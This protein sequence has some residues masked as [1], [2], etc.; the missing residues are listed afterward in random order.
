MTRTYRILG[1]IL[2]LVFGAALSFGAVAAQDPVTINWWHISTATDQAA[3]WQNL[4][5]E[6]TAAHP[7]V[8]IDITILENDAFKQ[9]LTTVMQAG[10]PP[11]LFQSWG[12]AVLWN[13]ANNGLVRD[14][15]PELSGDWYDSFA[16]PAAVNLYG[17][18]DA[19]YGVPWDW[20]AVGM[21]YNKALFAQ[22]G[23]DAVP[24]TWSEFLTDVQILKDAGITPISVGEG[25]TWTGHFW[26]V[27]LATRIGGKDA[28]LNAYDRTGSFADQPFVDAGQ[29]LADLV[30]MEPF[31]DGFLGV[32]HNDS[33]ALFGNGQAAMMLQGQWAI[34][35][36][37]SQSTSG[38]GI[39]ADLGWFPFP[40][41][42]GGAGD[43][44]D[45]F[46]GGN[47]FAVGKNA[48]DEAI[49]F[50]K[51]IT[52]PENNAAEVG[53]FGSVPTVKGT[54]SAI[55]DPILQQIVEARN[56][57]PYFQLYYDQF[58]P[59]A[60]GGAVNDSVATI[61]AGTAS[62]AEAAQAIEDVAAMELTQ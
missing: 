31:E 15:S 62:P 56:G 60:V 25:E 27:Y 24:T 50:L 19:Y 57:A 33:E 36:Q 61:F 41:V 35:A 44:A 20:G 42:E 59:P 46:G 4:A 47:G 49:D 51:F 37:A 45:V 58:L 30:A 34:T 22:A 10:D 18:N 21:F 17:Q 38:E 9:K 28:F 14:I 12:G 39:G 54:D 3:F 11:D 53:V 2:M 40:M 13:F 8:T 32:N 23:I 29:K 55:T 6:Y 16:V 26:W 48:P 52:S 1:L 5:D 7:N 43:P